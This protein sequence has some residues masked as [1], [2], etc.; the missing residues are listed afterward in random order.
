M[1]QVGVKR[2]QTLT[3][4]SELLLIFQQLFCSRLNK[5]TLIASN[6]R[7]FDLVTSEEIF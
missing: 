4:N 5:Y 3:R 7:A 2:L 1:M 6:N